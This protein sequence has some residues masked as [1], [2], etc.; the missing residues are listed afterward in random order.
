LYA[1]FWIFSQ[2]A[3][4][5]RKS[6]AEP[7]R[8]PRPQRQP[9]QHPGQAQVAGMDRQEAAVA[10]AKPAGDNVRAEVEEF[11]RR[12]R[13]QGQGEERAPQ[14]KKAEP[15]R[16]RIEVLVEDAVEESTQRSRRPIAPTPSSQPAPPPQ[17]RP[18][19]PT[20]PQVVDEIIE[21]APVA[22]PLQR[23]HLAEGVLF[24]H[25]RHLGEQIGQTDERLEAHLHQKFD[26]TLGNLVARDI[27]PAEQVAA[28]LATTPATEI[29]A[30]L[31]TPQGMQQA[32]ILSEILQR[33]ADRW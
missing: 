7:K 27:T 26:H 25:A 17:R 29:A 4:A 13:Q 14:P 12:V 23:R 5:K 32:V 22:V 31:A 21:I 8:R 11:L 33:P 18:Q 10:E 28:A 19:S 1:A 15:R 6:D 2:F 16:P 30:L 3:E 24:E 20:R 9:E